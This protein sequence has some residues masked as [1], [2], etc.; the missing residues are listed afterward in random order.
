MDDVGKACEYINDFLYFTMRTDKSRGD[1]T[2]IY[3]SGVNL[4]RFLPITRGRHGLGSNPALRGLQIVKCGVRDL[5][6]SRSASPGTVRGL[7]CSAILPTDETWFRESLLIENAPI[8]FPEE[9]VKFSVRDL[10]RSIFKAC[11]LEM[12]LPDELPG[13]VELQHFIESAVRQYGR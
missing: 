5:A 3:C 1:G 11:R 10:L 6:L 8:N 2:F 7:D 4:T 12:N 13:P 9:V